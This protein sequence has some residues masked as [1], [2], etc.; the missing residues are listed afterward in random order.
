MA[1]CEYPVPNKLASAVAPK[2]CGEV[3]RA[4]LSLVPY[5]DRSGEIETRI[6]PL[7]LKHACEIATFKYAQSLRVPFTTNEIIFLRD[8]GCEILGLLDPADKHG[9]FL[10]ECDLFEPKTAEESLMVLEA[11]KRL[12]SKTMEAFRQKHQRRRRH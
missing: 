10:G 11:H 6:Q 3:D 2:L 1:F 12:P 4:L 7:C 8:Q 9:P 5:Q